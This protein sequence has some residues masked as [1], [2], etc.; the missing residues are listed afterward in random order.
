MFLF[1]QTIFEINSNN[2]TNA[3][4]V[5]RAKRSRDT[6]LVHKYSKARAELIVKP[7]VPVVTR[8][9]PQHNEDEDEI[10]VSVESIY[11]RM[12]SCASKYLNL[13]AEHIYALQTVFSEV[14]GGKKRKQDNETDG[15]KSKKKSLSGKDEEFYIPYRP[16]D[17]DSERGYGRSCIHVLLLFHMFNEEIGK[18]DCVICGFVQ[19]ESWGRRWLFRAAGLLCGFGPDGRWE[20]IFK[21]A[22]EPNEMVSSA[23]F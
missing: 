1:P 7:A 18:S 10:Q 23:G 16:K 14:V 4:E 3:S 2:K 6:H 5:M 17:F 13:A 15:M 9:E 8:T 20:Q 21:P 19:A 22:Q 11:C 12:L